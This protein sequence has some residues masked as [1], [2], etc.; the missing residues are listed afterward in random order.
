MIT[1]DDCYKKY[2]QPRADGKYLTLWDVPTEL[3]IGVIP[4]RIYCNHD[5]I[6]PLS[7]AFRALIQTGLVSELR[8]WDGCFNIRPMRGVEHFSMKM[9][10]HSWAIAVDLNAFENGQGKIP[11]LSDG[12]VQCFKNSG[13]DWGGDFINSPV[14]GMHFQLKKL[15]I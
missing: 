12:F 10:L 8:T 15:F 7:S 4:K 1:S 6:L 14:D 2:G 13:F 9:S 5:L 3:E 11:K